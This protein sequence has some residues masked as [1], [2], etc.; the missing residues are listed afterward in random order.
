MSKLIVSITSDRARGGIANSLKTYSKAMALAGIEHTIIISNSAPALDELGQMRNVN[1]IIIPTFFM[2]LHILTRF[3]FHRKIRLLMA[4]ANAI[5]LHNGKHAE[6]I[7]RH[8]SKTYVIN[9]NGKA[10]HLNRAPNIIFLN[11]AAKQ[12]FSE[13]F[14][15]LSTSCHVFG[16]GF[17]VGDEIIRPQQPPEIVKVVSA[18]RLMEKK[19]YRDLVETAR[20]LASKNTP[21]HI[22]IF[23]EG[24]DEAYLKQKITDYQLRNIDI[25]PWTKT[26]RAEYARADIFC[27][28]SHGES[29]PLVIGEALETGLAI[30]STRTN[31]G[32]EYFNYYASKEHPIGLLSDIGSAEQMADILDKLVRD[33]ELRRKM[34]ANA[35]ALLTT[36][37]SLGVLGEKFT[38]LCDKASV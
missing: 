23:G 11:H 3:V 7:N 8:P 36:R 33:H 4:Q 12:N 10:R 32:L 16:H 5:F 14:E 15:G 20:I 21:C 38:E 18:G 2:R 35:R 6:Q 27:T 30:A 24:P 29:F 13:T 19:G 37:L 1:I 22:T 17:D 34:S 9:H 25:Q 28:S 31:G 26:L